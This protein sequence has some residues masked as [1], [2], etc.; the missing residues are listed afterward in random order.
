[1]ADVVVTSRWKLTRKGIR[2]VGKQVFSVTG[3][4]NE[5]RQSTFDVAVFRRRFLA[6]HFVL[7]HRRSV[8]LHT[9]RE[10]FRGLVVKV[11]VHTL[12]IAPLR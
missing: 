2:I 4:G 8:G 11:K 10:L 9:A 6:H 7:G 12:D 3:L 5:P 1:M